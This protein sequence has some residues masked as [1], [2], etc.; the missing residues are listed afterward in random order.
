MHTDWTYSKKT[1]RITSINEL[2]VGDYVHTYDS[3]FWKITSIGRDY[4][5]AKLIGPYSS[6]NPIRLYLSDGLTIEYNAVDLL[7]DILNV[8]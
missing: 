1:K 8:E 3:G 4:I 7:C 6:H 2:Q 5:M